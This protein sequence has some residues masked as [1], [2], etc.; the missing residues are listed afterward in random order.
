MKFID[1]ARSANMG[2]N[3]FGLGF[4]RLVTWLKLCME[5][6]PV[7]GFSEYTDLLWWNNI[8]N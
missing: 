3:I 8:N 5:S 1:S 4:F 2:G 6:D 7:M